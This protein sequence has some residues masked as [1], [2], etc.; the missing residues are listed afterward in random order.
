[1]GDNME[2][3]LYGTRFWPA[4]V[5]KEGD[6]ELCDVVG[7]HCETGDRL[8]TDA[9]LSAPEVGDLLVIPVTGAYCHS[10]ANNYNAMPRPPVI[11]VEDGDAR[12]AMRRETIA[13]LLERAI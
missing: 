5:D 13:D 1:M 9:W 2:T 6:P 3:A 11:F 7:H 10:M 4:I 8:A 12:V